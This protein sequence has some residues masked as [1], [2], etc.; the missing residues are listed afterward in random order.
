[1]A[2][3]PGPKPSLVTPTTGTPEPNTFLSRLQKAFTPGNTAAKLKF[4]GVDSS[5]QN[6]GPIS[7]EALA[8][9]AKAA[10]AAENPTQGG[11]RR[12]RKAKVTHRHSRKC[13]HSK[14]NRSRS[15]K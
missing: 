4:D 10:A 9:N 1:M 5:N 12:R 8:E 3:T 13:K 15:R 7:P 14:K 2:G 11:G 6:P